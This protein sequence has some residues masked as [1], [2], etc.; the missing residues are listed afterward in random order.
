MSK[1]EIGNLAPDFILKGSDGETHKLSDY[2]GKKVVLYFYPKDNT[3]GCSTQACDFRDSIPTITNEN[4]VVIGISKDSLA[5]HDKFIA[6][7]GLPFLLL[8]DEDKEVCALYDV[9]KEKNMYG[10]KTIG[11]ERSTFLIDEK[12]IL[13]KEFRKVKVKDH[14]NDVIENLKKL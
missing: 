10:R 1:I 6:K 11:I 2:L 12:G 5:S 13:R 3:P 7:F 14:I 9:L 8:S 4:A